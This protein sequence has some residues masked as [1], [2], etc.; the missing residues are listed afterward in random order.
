MSKPMPETPAATEVQS[1]FRARVA[2]ARAR[3]CV[4]RCHFSAHGTRSTRRPQ[5][6]HQTRYGA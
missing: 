1:S 6:G 2:T 3:A 5:V 4:T